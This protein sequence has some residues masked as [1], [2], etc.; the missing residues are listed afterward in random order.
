LIDNEKWNELM[1][2]FNN[3]EDIKDKEEE[4]VEEKKEL[5]QYLFDYG[6][7]LEFNDSLI[8]FDYTNYLSIFN[9]LIIPGEERGR[10]YKFCELYEEFYEPSKHDIDIKEYE[11]KEE[12]I[13]NLTL[14]KYP[15]FINYKF[16]EIIENSFK[17][18]YNK[19]ERYSLSQNKQTEIFTQKGKY[20]Y[21]PIKMS[22]IGYPLSGKKVQSN[23]ISLKYPKIKIFNPEE[24]FENKLEEYKKLKEPV[25]SSTKN[26]NLKPN[27][28]EQLNKEREEKLE[29]FKPV[30]EIIKPYLD[31]LEEYN[32]S[33]MNLNLH[34]TNF[35]EDILN[36]IYLNL[37]LYE[38]NLAFPD[39]IESK[40]KLM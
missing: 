14:P 1:E 34:E 7:K 24:I 29:Q 33:G 3:W 36:D 2:R 38:L 35:K 5:S 15:N 20:F 17:N 13:E 30:L 12:E 40:N 18:K 16:Y 10:K 19:I 11:P 26:K 39:Y 6:Y 8:M 31:Y 25:E 4:I 23:L 32:S 27:Q 22:F 21:L 37:L 9:D 28:L